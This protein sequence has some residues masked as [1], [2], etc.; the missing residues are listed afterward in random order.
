LA[1]ETILILDNEKNVTWTLKT[2]LENEGY[3][4]VIVD[5]VERAMRDFTE[6]KVSGLITEYW[7]GNSRTLGAIRKLKETFSESYVMMITNQ[8]VK[9]EEYEE[10]MKSGIDDYF[11]KPIPIKK[12]LLHLQKGLKNRGLLIE[13]K[14]LERELE[15][16]E[17]EKAGKSPEIEQRY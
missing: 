7:I 12:I 11:L 14:R 4:V 5:S 8:P 6:F 16:F 2:L 13:K 1:K 17:S 9:D 3:P 10:M 15:D